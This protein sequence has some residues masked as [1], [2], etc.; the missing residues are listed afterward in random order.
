MQT[1]LK[2]WLTTVDACAMLGK[3]EGWLRQHYQELRIDR[4]MIGRA[5]MYNRADINRVAVQIGT[6]KEE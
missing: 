3:S 1:S 4:I 6:R 5:A 2:D